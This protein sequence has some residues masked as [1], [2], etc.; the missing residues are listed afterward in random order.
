MSE[1]FDQ[2]SLNFGHVI[3]LRPVRVYGNDGVVIFITHLSSPKHGHTSGGSGRG[4]RR[5]GGRG[6]AGR[7]ADRTIRPGDKRSS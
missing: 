6:R 3:L 4:T 7:D 5:G 2:F 1:K